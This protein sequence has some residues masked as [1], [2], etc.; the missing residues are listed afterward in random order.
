M[1]RTEIFEK[2]KK[3]M[4]KAKVSGKA[5]DNTFKRI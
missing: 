5:G 3:A 2:C 4:K 1:A